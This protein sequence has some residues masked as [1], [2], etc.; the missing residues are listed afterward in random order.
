MHRHFGRPS[1][2][3]TITPYATTTHTSRY[4]QLA[5]QTGAVIV[6]T[7]GFDSIPA[8][9]LVY[10]SNKTLKDALGPQAQLGLSQTFYHV[11]GGTSGGTLNTMISDIEKTPRQVLREANEDYA[12]SQG[13]HPRDTL[14]SDFT[15]HSP[16]PPLCQ[17][18]AIPA[19]RVNTRPRS[20]FRRR[21]SM[22]RSGLW[23]PSTEASC[24]ARSA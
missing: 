16:Y 9:I 8:D 6:N 2:Q 13:E 5:T 7:C 24:S 11:R 23:A 22:A 4:D 21:G 12:I 14:T 20:H 15:N 17:S 19:L 10:L 18:P 1:C 3:H